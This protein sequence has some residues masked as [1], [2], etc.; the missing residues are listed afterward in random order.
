MD[1]FKTSISINE[2]IYNEITSAVGSNSKN[3]FLCLQIPGIILNANDYKYDYSSSTLKPLVVEV[4]ESRLANKMFDPCKITESD[5]GFSLPYQYESALDILTPK[6]NKEVV[7]LKKRLRKLLLSKYPYDFGCGIETKYTLQQVYFRLYD[8]YMGALNEWLNIQRN[9]KEDLQKKY[10]LKSEFKEAYIEWYETEAES[11]LNKIDE[12]KSKVLAVFSPNDMKILEGVLDSGSGAKL[13]EAR[14]ALKNARKLTPTGGYIY[15]VRFVPS[16]W[17]ELIGTSFTPNDLM[18][19]PDDL[20]LELQNYSLRRMQLSDYIQDICSVLKEEKRVF[21]NDFS[22]ELTIVKSIQTKIKK[23]SSKIFD[24]YFNGLYEEKIS[25]LDQNNHKKNLLICLTD[26]RTATKKYTFLNIAA[27]LAA[28]A[29]FDI[30]LKKIGSSQQVIFYKQISKIAE[31]RIKYLKAIAILITKLETFFKENELSSYKQILVPTIKQFKT[32]NEKINLTLEQIKY[33]TDLQANPLEGTLPKSQIPKGFV[34]VAINVEKNTIS[35]NFDFIFTGASRNSKIYE[36]LFEDCTLSI[37]MNVAKIGIERDWF[38]PG[39]F[40]HTK[41][42]IKL[43]L[44][45]IS[46]EREDYIGFDDKRL[47]DMSKCIFPCYPV[48]M[49]IARDISIIFNLNEKK[50]LTETYEYIEKQAQSGRGFLMFQNMS[51][52]STIQQSSSHVSTQGKNIVVKIDSTQLIGFYLEATRADKSTPLDS[53]D[54]AHEE[55]ENVPQNEGAA[56]ILS[57]MILAKQ[58]PSKAE[59]SSPKDFSSVLELIND[60]QSLIEDNILFT[61]KS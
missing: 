31:L 37:T 34:Q 24:E 22:Q 21:D 5:N 45:L 59:K 16:N 43:G 46:P 39:I 50:S 29:G 17:F 38:N 57:K 6:L 26:I 2:E 58:V 32:I 55:I 33:G 18:K 10:P 60:Y 13:Q 44:A 48:A 27:K 41:N 1:D 12:K 4:N 47:K 19:S 7:D 25:V 3:Q 9:K 36:K 42:M 23:D 30:S 14:N 28:N 53:I 49:V 61:K 35:K 52:N 54:N 15:P 11:Y 8:E 56:G 40:A 20:S 51:G